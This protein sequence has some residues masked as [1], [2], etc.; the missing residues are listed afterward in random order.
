MGWFS[1]LGWIQQES[2]GYN[3]ELDIREGSLSFLYEHDFVQDAL[4]SPKVKSRSLQQQHLVVAGSLTKPSMTYETQAQNV[5]LRIVSKMHV[6]KFTGW[7][8]FF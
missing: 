5:K 4:W 8:I 3:N 1:L 7:H 2:V 6:P